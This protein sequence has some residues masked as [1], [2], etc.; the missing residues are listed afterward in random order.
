MSSLVDVSTEVGSGTGDD[1]AKEGKLSDTAV[2]DLNVTKAVE[3]LLVGFVEESERIEESDR[4]LG[5]KLS[6]EGVERGGGLAGL[7][8]GE[9]GGGGGE[10]GEDSK[11]HHG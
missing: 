9:G 10:G 5:A 11:L 8:R 6:L 4:G 2:L 1:V 3:S 7:D